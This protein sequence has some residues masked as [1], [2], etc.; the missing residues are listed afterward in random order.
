MSSPATEF[1]GRDQIL[2]VVVEAAESMTKDWEHALSAPPGPS[3]LLV[4]DLGCQSLDIVMLTADL[5]RRL[6]RS[7]IPFE[8]LLLA[9]G[10]PAADISLGALAEFLWEHASGASQGAAR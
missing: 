10:K 6:H 2:A 7:D 8:R 3:T 1:P 9:N 4:A 5:S